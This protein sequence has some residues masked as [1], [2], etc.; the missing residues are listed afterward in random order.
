MNILRDAW[1]LFVVATFINA[2]LLKHKSKKHISKNPQLKAGYDKFFKGFL[3]VGN[4]P[5][6]IIGAGN[7]AGYTQNIF[8]Y[9]NPRSLNPF[10]LTFHIAIIILRLLCA[11]WVY[12]NNGAEFI[13]KHPGLLV[14]R[15]FG[16]RN[17][18][19]SAKRIKISLGIALLG[20]IIAM[21]IMWTGKFPIP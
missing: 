5:W 4:I 9:F 21:V 13:E 14:K 8:E 16:Y 19:L 2:F 11:R 3:I 1:I 12:F 7:T 6:I 10:V 17:E 15:G 20:G 18:N